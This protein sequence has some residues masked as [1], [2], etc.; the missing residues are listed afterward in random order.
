MTITPVPGSLV[1][2]CA[3]LLGPEA[4]AALQWLRDAPLESGV[5]AEEVDADGRAVGNGGD[6]A[7]AG[8]LAPHRLV[9][10]ARARRAA[11]AGAR[12]GGCLSPGRRAARFGFARE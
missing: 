3:R 12:A 1:Q 7:L 5:A 4:S 8:L 11:R 9:R 10:R 2:R 6:A